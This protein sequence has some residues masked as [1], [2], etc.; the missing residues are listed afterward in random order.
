MKKKIF[1]AISFIAV[2]VCLFAVSAL[3]VEI[4]GIYYTLNGSGENATATVNNENATN[5][6]LENVVIPET[7]TYGDV[8][9]TVT[10]VDHHAFSGSQSNWGKNQTIKSLYIPATVSSIGNHF[11]R[12]C[13]S[14]ETVVV[15]ARNVNGIEL[16]DAEFYNCSSLKYVD[17]SESDITS[18]RQYTFHGCSSLTTLK[19]PTRLT[20]IG[21]QSLRNCSSL[22]SLDL[23]DIPVTEIGA[24]AFNG[25]S[26]LSSLKLPTTLVSIGNNCMQGTPVVGT[27]IF[28]DT[29][30][31]LANDAIAQISLYMVV[32]PD[33]SNGHNYH[34]GSFHDV[35]PTVIIYEGDDYT[36]LTNSIDSFKGYTH[37]LIKCCK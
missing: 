1:L 6:T 7:V 33:V 17:M 27:L 16:G 31:T 9:Y 34:S 12:E 19:L 29:F 15:K 23:T 20:K 26:Q 5:C 8:T 10:S 35:Y 32:F 22:E 28:P 18:F 14:I 4:D 25:C 2:L 11:L 37:A 13:K 30:A 3:A 21:S 24:W 36:D